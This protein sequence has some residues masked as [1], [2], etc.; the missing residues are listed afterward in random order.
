MRRQGIRSFFIFLF[1]IIASFL[2]VANSSFVVDGEAKQ[3]NITI[4]EGNKAVCYNARTGTKY[5]TIEKALSVAKDDTANNDTIYVIPGT[6]PTITTAI[7]I[8]TISRRPI[9]SKFKISI[10]RRD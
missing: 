10:I 4:N 2:N 7:T 1:L 5:T 8:M 9:P 3:E 6:N